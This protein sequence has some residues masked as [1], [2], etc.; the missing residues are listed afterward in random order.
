TFQTGQGTIDIMADKVVFALPFSIL[1]H[2]V[3]LSAAG[4]SELKLTAID[5]LP[6]GSN[7]KLNVQFHRRHW[8]TLG[9]N[10][11]SFSDTG[12]QA[13][14][15]VSRGQAGTAGILVGYSGGNHADTFGQG[16]AATQA[17][18]FLGQI[19]PVFPG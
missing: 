7:S 13:S 16:T 3:D 9:G 6:M 11:D 12:Y 15:E 1:R 4:F 17:E 8:A 10:G 2:S 19:E 5:E 18:L 14:W